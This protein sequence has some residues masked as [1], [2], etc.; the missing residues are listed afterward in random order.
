MK[1]TLAISL[2]AAAFALAGCI[3]D[4]DFDDGRRD[5]ERAEARR[6]CVEVARDRGFQSIDV[7]SVQR[8]ARNRWR[9]IMRGRDEGRDRTLPCVYNERSNE[10]HLTT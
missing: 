10:A 1:T 4:L 3:H 2:G 7:D 9:V 5:E 8:E 6:A